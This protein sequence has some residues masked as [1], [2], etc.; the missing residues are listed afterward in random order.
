LHQLESLELLTSMLLLASL[1][2]LACCPWSPYFAGVLET[3]E[4]SIAGVPEI[5]AK[6]ES[7]EKHGVWDPMS[8]L[9]DYN[10]TLLCPQQSR[11]K[12]I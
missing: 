12:H 2:V 9:V 6:A 5:L 10:L 4:L 11:L 3:C 1:I 8:K 7:K